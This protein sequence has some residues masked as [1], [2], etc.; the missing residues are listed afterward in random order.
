MSNRS[1]KPVLPRAPGGHEAKLV[2]SEGVA[3]GRPVTVRELDPADPAVQH[4]VLADVMAEHAAG[5]ITTFIRYKGRH[6]ERWFPQL[7]PPACDPRV[8]GFFFPDG[9]LI[10]WLTVTSSPAVPGQA[11]L[12]MIIRP[13]Y[14]DAGL[15]TAALLH[16]A[17]HL[18][19]I[20]R[21]PAATGVFFETQAVNRRV[22]HVARKLPVAH[23][24][25]R[26]D[27][28]KGGITM[29]QYSSRR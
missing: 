18:P 8:L 20:A 26:V 10:G 14:R 7:Y 3:L 1:T 2:F 25:S 27:D 4:E 23:V 9:T 22:I 15:G 13:P 24:G 5:T 16:V 11:V 28:L 6:P 19:A 29:L 21:D 17:K 12:G